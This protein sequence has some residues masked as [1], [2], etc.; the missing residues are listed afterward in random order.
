MSRELSTRVDS[1]LEFENGVH[2]RETMMN[3]AIFE[4]KYQAE[5]SC[6]FL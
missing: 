1:G 5:I 4:S 6:L 2:N 3:V